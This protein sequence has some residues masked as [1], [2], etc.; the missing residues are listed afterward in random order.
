MF[1][2]KKQTIKFSF[3]FN[4]YFEQKRALIDVANRQNDFYN[5]Q[6]YH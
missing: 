5:F 2:L 3:S 1:S 4:L 6:C